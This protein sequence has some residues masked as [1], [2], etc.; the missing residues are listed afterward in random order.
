MPEDIWIEIEIDNILGS[1]DEKQTLNQRFV[2]RHFLLEAGALARNSLKN[3]GF[4][5]NC[6][7]SRFSTQ[8]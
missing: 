8:L 6:L 5:Y 1:F 4:I 2:G 3:A 7:K